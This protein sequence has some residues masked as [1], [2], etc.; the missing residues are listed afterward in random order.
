VTVKVDGTFDRTGLPNPLVMDPC[1]T[2][3]GDRIAS[4]TCRL[5]GDE[6]KA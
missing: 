2:V 4:L 5:A 1:V 3:V 6:S